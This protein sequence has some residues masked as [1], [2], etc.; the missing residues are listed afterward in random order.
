MLK[1]D[2]YYDV[3]HPGR[4]MDEHTDHSFFYKTLI[5]QRCHIGL[6]VKHYCVETDALSNQHS[7]YILVSKRL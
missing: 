3:N 2:T 5:I 7:I 4:N 1:G 6:G